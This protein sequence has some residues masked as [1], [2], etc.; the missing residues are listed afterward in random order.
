[1]NIPQSA[2]VLRPNP[3]EG[4]A[5]DP[6]PMIQ[7]PAPPTSAST[8]FCTLWNSS[9]PSFK[10]V[11]FFLRADT[12]PEKIRRLPRSATL[13]LDL[14]DSIAPE[15]KAAQ[16]RRITELLESGVLKGR[17]T[18]LR[19]NG[20]DNPDEMRAD[21]AQCIHPD[22][23]GLMLPMVR[24][25]MEVKEIAEMVSIEE[26]KRDL[27]PGHT[28][29]VPLIERPA[30]VLE[31]S[32][33]ALASRRNVALAFGHADFCREMGADMDEAAVQV[34]R[35]MVLMAA[36]AHGLEA[37]SPVYLQLDDLAGFKAQ[38]ERMK[39]LGF[40]GCFALTP[41]QMHTALDVFGRTQEEIQGARMVVAAIEA[42]GTVAQLDGRMIGPPM[43]KRALNILADVQDSSRGVA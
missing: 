33:I 36:K 25:A 37:I 6:I 13:L 40:D 41:G 12:H 7:P 18:M 34:P 32:A 11:L 3:A 23:L 24:S 42:Q 10:S 15:L 35:S 5:P 2:F 31:A 43:L 30:A 21:L 8:R 22:L 9:K 4:N 38:N 14:E 39:R 19:I 29:F 28:C 1:M 16:R 26:K 17:K 20:P 27:A